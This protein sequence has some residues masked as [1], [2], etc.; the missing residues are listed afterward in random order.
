MIHVREQELHLFFFL[1]FFPSHFSLWCAKVSSQ[2]LSDQNEWYQKMEKV[3][4][5][6]VR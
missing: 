3:I 4:T 5:N 1:T 2:M 6:S